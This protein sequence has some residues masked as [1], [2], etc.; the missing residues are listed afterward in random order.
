MRLEPHD[1]CGGRKQ[2]RDFTYVGDVVEANMIASMSESKDILGEVFN[3]G[4]GQN[5]SMWDL[6]K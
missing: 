5:H 1:D 2:R 3:I 4:T 6:V